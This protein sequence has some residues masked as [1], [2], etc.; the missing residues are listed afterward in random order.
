M[1]KALFPREDAAELQPL[2]KKQAMPRPT[3]I[4]VRDRL[5]TSFD[6][7]R[8]WRETMGLPKGDTKEHALRELT[9]TLSRARTRYALIGGVAVQLY[10]KE[11]RTTAD[12]DVALASYEDLPRTELEAAGFE[13]EKRFEHSD[14]WRAPGPGPRKRRI[15]V[16]FSVDKL[17]P[18]AVARAETFRVSGMRLKVASLADLVLLKLEAAEEAERRPSKRISDV[19]DVLALLEEHPELEAD[20]PDARRRAARA[21]MIAT[22]DRPRSRDDRS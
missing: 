20:L 13:H 7:D 4:Q 1:S 16:Q 15:A 6:L 12:L 9:E 21:S 22:T 2:R 11:P 5:T 17:T 10:T 14:N 8:L 18:G 19:R 3:A